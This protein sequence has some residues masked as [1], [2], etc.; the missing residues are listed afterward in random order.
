MTRCSR[1]SG[2]LPSSFVYLIVSKAETN[3]TA[4]VYAGM[5]SRPIRMR[6][7]EHNDPTRKGFT[8]SRGPWSLLAVTAYLSPECA[9]RAEQQLKRSKYAKRNLIKRISRIRTL[10]D[11]H[12][13]QYPLTNKPRP[14]KS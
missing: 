8:A 4:I 13:I 7:K 9:R 10:C 11:R 12:G 2:K 3:K 14:H 5:T 1:L 6:F